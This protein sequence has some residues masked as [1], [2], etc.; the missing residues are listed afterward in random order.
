MIIKSMTA[1]FGALRQQRLDLEEG[2]NLIQ[3][4]NEAGKSTW[5]AFLRAMFYGIPTKER[6]RQG[7]IAEKNR[8]QPW[9]GEPMEGRM[10]LVWQGRAITLHRSQRGSTPFGKFEAVDTL[11]G[12]PV[13]GLTAANAGEVLLGV[14]R[15]V[16]E[17]SAFVGQGATAVDAAPALEKRIAALVSSGLEDVSSTESRTRLRDWLNRRRHNKTGLIPKLEGELAALDETLARQAQA[18]HM[19]EQAR[20][21]VER[22][23]GEKGRLE[24]QLAAC[25]SAENQARRERYEAAQAALAQAQG[26]VDALEAALNR[27]GTPPDREQLRRAQEELN[28]LNTL[29]A[30]RRQAEAEYAQAQEEARIKAEAVEDPLFSGLSP[31]E[32]WDRASADVDRAKQ[33]LAGAQALPPALWLCL[34]GGLLAGVG[35]GALC[36]LVLRL[37][38]AVGVAAGAL[39][40]AVGGAVGLLI[41]RRRRQ[42]QQE[43]ADL[44]LR[45]YHAQCPE[46]I[47]ALAADY[48]ERCVVAAEA[49]R[50][51]E[52]VAAAQ[53][54]LQTQLDTAKAAL[55]A[56]VRP[57][58]PDVTDLFGVS[59]ALSRTLGLQEKQA[60]ALIRLEGARQL[61]DS[62]PKPDAL[63]PGHGAAPV[64]DLEGID[65]RELAMR[66]SAVEQELRRHSS[67]LAMARGEL[68][69]LGDPALFQARRESKQEELTRRQEEYQ[70]ISLAL[71]ALDRADS[72]LQSRFSPALNRRSGEILSA[73][74]EGRYE[75]V[76]LTRDFEATA[77]EAG[78]VLPRRA[79]ALSRGTLDQLYLAVRLAICQLAL[80]EEDPAPLVLD[81]ALTNFDDGRMAL[82]LQ[83]LLDL[84]Q[85]RQVLCFTCH[86]REGAW[87]SGRPGVHMAAL[88]PNSRT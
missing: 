53:V 52:A 21:E 33:A 76:S 32:A 51:M 75:G 62:L 36:L 20:Q 42:L 37:S 38:P 57:F 10:D 14:P 44:L 83:Y 67:V 24:G 39:L 15:E 86:S 4:P 73:L 8:Y 74:T 48:R 27:H 40:L 13:A 30:N 25:R 66:L 80:P 23:T 71:E 41:T 22:L 12:E 47:L 2:F 16:F 56:L 79:L 60:A 29:T 49:R 11:T 7:F 85:T 59:A 50:K 43:R 78:S 46:D 3:A 88:S 70:A 77:A 63:A 72:A 84:S 45:R 6:D 69:T 1:S 9:S 17:R 55:L 31:E 35:V 65:P 87:L 58:A 64:P 54:E 81:D 68:N 61:V 82:A 18:H 19:A 5:S 26:E 34:L 28:S